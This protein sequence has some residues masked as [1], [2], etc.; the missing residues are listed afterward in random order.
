MLSHLLE[1]VS[2]SFTS[3]LRSFFSDNLLNRFG[4]VHE[5]G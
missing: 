2:S 5:N 4:F 3:P 1:E